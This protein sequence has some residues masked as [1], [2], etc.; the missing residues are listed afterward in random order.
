MEDGLPLRSTRFDRTVRLR[1]DQSLRIVDET[2]HGFGRVF[3]LVYYGHV[4]CRHRA[5]TLKRS[6]FFFFV[7]IVGISIMN[8]GGPVDDAA[9]LNGTIEGAA[10]H[11]TGA[12][13]ECYAGGVGGV[14]EVGFGEGLREGRRHGVCMIGIGCSLCP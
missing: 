14:V 9:G 11:A 1:G 6:T 8:D 4:R 12:G 13:V 10:S 3:R 7:V 2:R 5:I